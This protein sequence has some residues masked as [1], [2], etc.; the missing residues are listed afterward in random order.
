MKYI[1]Y[2]L[3][4]I[5]VSFNVYAEK[6]KIGVILPLSGPT[7]DY[8]EAVKNGI[9]LAKEKNK[10]KFKN[11][12]FIYEDAM[13]KGNLAVQA[14]KKLVKINKVDIVY[15]WGVVYCRTI[16]SLA[17]KHKVPF[18]AQSVDPTI[19]GG[20]D[21]VI[22][23]TNYTD[24]YSNIL[25]SKL[26]N[27]KI[28]KYAAV[29]TD[30][31]YLEESYQ[32]FKRNLKNDESITLVD[33]FLN[34]NFDFRSTISRLKN[35]NYD[36]LLVYLAPGQV[37]TFN[38]QAK[39]LKLNIQIVGNNLFESKSEIRASS[40]SMDE[41]ILAN[42]TVTLEFKKEYFK[43]YNSD[44]QVTFAGYAYEF[45]LLAEELFNNYSFSSPID[46]INKFKDI[47]NKN[48][49]AMGSY[50][51]KDSKE[52]GKYFSFPIVLKTIKNNKVILLDDKR[53]KNTTTAL[54]GH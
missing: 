47:E 18:I 53:D 26:R 23:F 33:R 4:A 9:E 7:A 21:Y 29:V 28:K 43:R 30:N 51:Y 31:P 10:D 49:Y 35:S 42:N 34:T 2:I 52:Y 50:F 32:A 36:A 20:K 45:A 22:R 38:K 37:A 3:L 46:I 27:R 16:S 11:I 14:F 41:S 12:E 54:K 8:G 48:S 15:A 17:E 13:Y 39:D 1:L 40:N 5:L 19:A 44:T 6:F 24:E 25:L